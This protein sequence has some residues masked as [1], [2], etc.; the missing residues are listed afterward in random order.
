MFGAGWFFL[1]GFL[2]GVLVACALFYV[3][4]RR[5]WGSIE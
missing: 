2:F 1:G 4:V 5:I 3:A